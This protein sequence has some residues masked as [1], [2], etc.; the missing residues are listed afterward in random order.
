MRMATPNCA[1]SAWQS[2]LHLTFKQ[3]VQLLL[4][5]MQAHPL[6]FHRLAS[7]RKRRAPTSPRP[8]SLALWSTPHPNSSTSKSIVGSL[9]CG[10]SVACSMSSWL[11]SLH[12]STSKATA[13]TQLGAFF[14]ASQITD[15]FES[16]EIDQPKCFCVT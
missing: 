16:L 12:F 4:P 15:S 9:T 7:P 1:T 14:I 13:E 8:H 11:V 3:L 2:S 5:T 10:P 6:Q